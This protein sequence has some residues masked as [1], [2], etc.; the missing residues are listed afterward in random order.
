MALEIEEQDVREKEA[1][2]LGMLGAA[3]LAPSI[4]NPAQDAVMRCDLTACPNSCP[5]RTS[6]AWIKPSPMQNTIDWGTLSRPE[7]AAAHAQ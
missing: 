5:I 2:V 4:N 3:R 7:V 6:G 1:G